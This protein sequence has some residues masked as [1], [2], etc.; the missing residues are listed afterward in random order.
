MRSHLGTACTVVHSACSI[1]GQVLYVLDT[2]ALGRVGNVNPRFPE[3]RARVM[4]GLVA[5][6]QTMGWRV[7]E[8]LDSFHESEPC[9]GIRR[10][11]NDV[12]QG[13]GPWAK[14]RR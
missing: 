13:Q 8:A 2:S 7:V 3:S 6:I 10:Q 1:Q 14:T 5:R 12:R 11:N 4:C 9:R